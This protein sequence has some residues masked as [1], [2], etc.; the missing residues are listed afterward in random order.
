M[1][2]LNAAAGT[3]GLTGALVLNGDGASTIS[4][5]FTNGGTLDLDT[6]NGDGG[7][8]LTIGT[9]ANTGTALIGPNDYTL[10]AATK[11]TL[12]GLTNA[13]GAYF[14]VWGSAS[15]A[16]T[17]AFSS[18]SAFTSNSGNF[19]LIDTAPLTLSNAFTNT[20]T[21]TVA[22]EGTA[23]LTV[24]GAFTNGGAL[25]L[26]IV[27]GNGGGGLTIGGTLANTGTALI[28]P[29][30]YTLSAA[31]K[32]TLG[33]L[34]NASGAY[35]E[36]WGS[37]SHA[38]TLAF[39]SASAFTSNSGNFWLIDTAPLT[40]S[41]AFTN[42]STGTVALEGTAELT[43]TGAFTNGGALELDIVS[44]N[45]GGGL[46]IGGTLANTGTALI[47]PNDYTLS[48][49][50]KV[51]L[52]GLTNASGAK[53]Y[54]YGSASHAA[55]LAFSSASAFTSNSGNFWLIDTAPLTL[56]NAFTNTS[57]GTVA[58]E[59]TAELTV[60]GAFTNGGALELDIV[61]GNGG[62]GLTIG[63]TLANTGTALI[64]PNDYT[65]SAATKVTLGGLTNASG[66][67]FEVWGSASHAATL[68][69]SSASAFTSNSGNFW[70]IDTAPL[71]LSNAFTNTSTGTVALEGTAELT[72][73]GA[74][75]NGG[76]LELDIVSGNG[77]GG[78]TIGGTLANTGTALIGPNDYTL[79]AAT[80]VTLGG[81]TNASGAY[82]EVWG[83]ASHAATL[84]F[85]S[86]SAFTSNS[87][88]FWLIDTAPLTLSNAFTNTS[89]GT[90]ALEG[91]A[92]LTVTGAFTNGG[93][94]ELDI[95]S[96]N[97]G[98]GLT[99]G[100]TL[101]NTGTALIG[102]N[103]YTLSAATKVTLGGL[104]NASGAYFEVWGSASHAATATVSGLASNAGT[105]ELGGT[106]SLTATG[107]FTNSG[108]L[109]LD[110]S[111]SG[112]GLTIDGTLA[113][114]GTFQVGSTSLSSTTTATLG[115]LSN[116]AEINLVGGSASAKANL[117]VKN[118]A[119]NTGTIFINAFGDLTAPNVNVTDGTLEGLGT[120]TGALNDT[121]GTVIGG[122]LN[123]T[124]GTLNVSGAYNQSGTGILQADI[125][126]GNAQQS[127]IISVTGSPGTPGAAG[128][129][130]L[131]GGTLLIDAE[132]ALALN[133]PYTV[134]SYGAGHLYG[135]FGQVKSEGAL[136]SHTGNSTSVNLGNGDTLDVFYN[137]AS[138]TVQVEMV[139]TP[140]ATTYE[141]HVGSG[142]WNASSAADWSPPG[143]GTTPSSTSNVVIGTG[144][145]GTVTL[146][147][148]QTINSLSITSGYTL[149]GGS[150]SIATNANVSL[151]SGGALTLDNMNVGG[152]FSDSGSA[153]LAGVLTI[154][155]GGQLTLTNGSLT[156]G[157]INGTGTF[158]TGPGT[159][160]TLK[161]I[162]IYKGTTYTA[163]NT[164][165]TDILGAIADKGAIQ[166]NGGGGT[167]GELE[168]TGAATLSG[169][170]VVGMTTATGGGN[171]IVD[172]NGQTLTNA[173]DVIEG[174]GTIGTNGH[175]TV[176]NGGTIDAN[177]AAGTKTSDPDRGRDHQ[178]QWRDRRVA[179][180][181]E[182][183]D[184]ADQQHHSEQRRRQRH[185]QWRRRAVEEC[186]DPGR[187]FERAGRRDDGDDAGHDGNP[188]RDHAWR[189][190]DQ[191][192][193]HLYGEQ[194][195][196]H[197]HFGR[198]CRQGRDPGER[199][200]RNQRRV[201]TDRGCDVER[202]RRGGD[203]DRNRRR[204]RHC[205][206]QRAN[207]DQ[208]RR[209]D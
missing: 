190:D 126:T 140:S 208:R 177:S 186:D 149:S 148:D 48:A 198:H 58:L 16:A 81:L 136:G 124:P 119:T 78:L 164:A 150:N 184:T 189:S 111:G 96:G 171:A 15:H 47:G 12:G 172:G 131:A 117:V 156:G 144:G 18:A 175:L 37:A 153:T 133:T 22:L 5:A 199:R 76:A 132:S 207:A 31:T 191:R 151:A 4:G 159:T 60:T 129:V 24:T 98:G 36:V 166:V 161:A 174:T 205:R 165:V 180:G 93:A 200:R 147:Q 94:L 109:D 33:G 11:V 57:T 141:W 40:L 79:S 145:S 157:G 114:T 34:T 46:T 49:A 179:G 107:P 2:S 100:G 30:D 101:A 69:F 139:T 8:S 50:T 62:G 97:G 154:N 170:G 71:T 23:E 66:A 123:S 35:F 13:S 86:A 115:G 88:N 83:S 53:F 14:E 77:G 42:T 38:A 59:G 67:Y 70:L 110:I 27:S 120:V 10:S 187:N 3:L 201:G 52:G 152:A 167:N 84:A 74:F 116:A 26:D 194:H 99:I 55:T 103:D 112:G 202:R 20:S 130:N 43:V 80:K 9:L 134:M 155:T 68:A 75:T 113:N 7:G 188:G 17:L 173:G 176:I 135:L 108:A 196:G 192:R 162:A 64:G 56:S 158:E 92:E 90:V 45:G 169:G 102:P 128:S 89:T 137:E 44:G 73:T 6:G 209:R 178:R 87:G 160:G 19:W 28:G 85:S 122:T 195:R 65:L 206:R 185:G 39:S 203:D 82:F 41:N 32:V 127:S 146:E 51:T 105:V 1:G 29:N 197:R 193:Q 54:V 182:R 63:G 138:G 25:E 121:G 72:V 106:A 95:V 118:T 142:T 181:D 104:T 91:T 163:S 168:L 183:R 125:N 143:N 204:Q 21:G 61:S